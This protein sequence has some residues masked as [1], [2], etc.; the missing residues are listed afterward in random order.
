MKNFL[1][2]ISLLFFTLI[3][4]SMARGD[5]PT[6]YCF[7]NPA[8]SNLWYKAGFASCDLD[9]SGKATPQSICL[10]GASCMF[11][12]P[13][14]KAIIEA[15]AVEYNEKIT[16]LDGMP[17]KLIGR[18]LNRHWNNTTPHE[19]FLHSST[20]V[21]KHLANRCQSLD[22]CQGPVLYDIQ[23]EDLTEEGNQLDDQQ[24]DGQILPRQEK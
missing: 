6:H 5:A 19:D 22:E 18:I 23:K 11:I 8:Q 10:E 15:E 1:P 13:K 16:T 2:T 12:T 7:Q 4:M 20:L 21:C 17:S 9:K 24:P 3:G 14:I